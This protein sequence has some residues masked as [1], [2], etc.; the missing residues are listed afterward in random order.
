MALLKCA[1]CGG[2]VSSDA[3]ACP[4]CGAKPPKRTS[5]LTWIV[6]GTTLLI[7][8]QCS[9]RSA[10]RDQAQAASAAKETARIASLSPEQRAA[11]QRAK[12]DAQRA[13]AMEEAQFQEAVLIT[14]QIKASMKNP[15]SFELVSLLR[16]PD[17]T[18]CYEYRGT[19]SFNA[20]VPNY[21]VV[22]PDRKVTA[23]SQDD[24]ATSWNKR[25]AKV[26][27]KDLTYVRRAM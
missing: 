5:L 8:V 12:E 18:L 27:G 9:M 23:G 20:V 26:A 14:R 6:A 15:A 2:P 17:G 16:M 7:V 13:K 25:C 22:T 24:V 11:E 4:K 10:E 3:K 19:N 21:A 1:T